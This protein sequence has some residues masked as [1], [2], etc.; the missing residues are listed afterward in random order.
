MRLSSIS[1]LALVFLLVLCGPAARAA[2]LAEHYFPEALASVP[3]SVMP[4]CSG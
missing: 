3:D 2:I 4:R 1:A